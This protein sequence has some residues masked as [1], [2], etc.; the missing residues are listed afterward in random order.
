M[1]VVGNVISTFVDELASPINKRNF[2]YYYNQLWYLVTI[3]VT[4]LPE[5]LA[6]A[7]GASA[8]EV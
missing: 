5:P 7:A 1:I 8:S 3:L 4:I 2:A 6:D